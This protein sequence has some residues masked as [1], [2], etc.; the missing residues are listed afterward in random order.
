MKNKRIETKKMTL[1][2]LCASVA[3][4]LSYIEF[5]LPPILTIAPGIKLG[6]PNIV[7]IWALYRLGNREAIV[8]SFVRLAISTLLFG[9]VTML[10]YSLAGAVLS[11]SVM[12]IL[13][14]LDFLSMEFL[15]LLVLHQYLRQMLL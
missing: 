12:L 9:N 8:I 13:K 1:L 4:I 7:I 3:L 11:L 6:L 15:V 2:A 5:M 10:W 14:K